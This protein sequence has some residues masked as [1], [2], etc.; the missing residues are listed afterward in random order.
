MAAPLCADESRGSVTNLPI[1]RFVSLKAPEGNVRRG[2]SLSHRIDW[3]FKRRAMPLMVTDEYGHWRRVQDAEGAGGWMHYSLLSGA[4]TVIV[5]EDLVPLLIKPEQG[6]TVNAYAEAGV[7]AR[8]GAC[9]ESWCR[10]SADGHRG[11]VEKSNLWGV[12]PD[13]IRD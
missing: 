3:V 5:T 12:K 9:S 2:P 4:R 6:S 7:V 10:I 13:E 1:P 11:W 8:L